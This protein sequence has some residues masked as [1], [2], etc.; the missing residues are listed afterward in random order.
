MNNQLHALNLFEFESPDRSNNKKVLQLKY[1]N[2][3][4]LI[5]RMVGSLT[6]SVDL[7]SRKNIV[8]EVED[9]SAEPK[10]NGIGKMVMK[11]MVV[12]LKSTGVKQLDSP[13]VSVEALRLRKVLFPDSAVDYYDV[14]RDIPVPIT[15]EQ[16]ILS[17]LRSEKV[18]KDEGTDYTETFGVTVRLNEI[19]TSEW[20]EPLKV[21]FID[22]F[23]QERAALLALNL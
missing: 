19:D 21:E 15:T 11:A 20:G 13:V 10:G 5:G 6:V 3:D 2:H 16:A 12:S 8:A 9:F 23:E 7:S 22:Y 1:V 18:G 17:T 4:Q 14:D